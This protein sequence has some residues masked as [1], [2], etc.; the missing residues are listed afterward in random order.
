MGLI[1][2]ALEAL[3]RIAL[4]LAQL[5]AVLGT[6]QAHAVRSALPYLRTRVEEVGTRRDPEALAAREALEA[7]EAAVAEIHS[8]TAA[9][10]HEAGASYRELSRVVCCDDTVR[11]P[12]RAVEALALAMLHGAE[13]TARARRDVAVD[14]AESAAQ[15]GSRSP[16]KD[17]RAR[18]A[19]RS[20]VVLEVARAELEDALGPS[21]AEAEA[22]RWVYRPG[23]GCD[24]CCDAHEARCGG[25]RAMQRLDEL[26]ER[27]GPD[28]PRG[29]A[30]RDASALLRC[31]DGRD[32]VE[33][34][35][36]GLNDHSV[37]AGS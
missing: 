13:A 24:R 25:C 16:L 20:V 28:T 7:A 11:D 1:R 22:L 6:H 31:D 14:A 9:A 17:E 30:L 2:S 18:A 37:G 36:V 33:L 29:V 19:R 32:D 3:H 12:W 15:V 5:V 27:E 34:V 21:A 8:V 23:C 4:A 10:T 35:D 26:A